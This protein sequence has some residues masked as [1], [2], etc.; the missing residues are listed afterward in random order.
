MQSI[1]KKIVTSVLIFES[2][3]I[4]KKY[5]PEIIAVTGNIGKTS[6]KDA[7]Y[8][9][10]KEFTTDIRRS[11]KSFNSEIG[12]PLTIIG[13]KN[14]W[15]NPIIWAK[16]IIQGFSLIIFKQNYPKTLILEVGA[17]KPHDIEDVS[18]WIHPDIVVMTAF[19]KTPV[20]VENFKDRDALIREKR[21]LVEALKENGT[22]IVNADDADSL[23]MKN[24]T[25]AKVMTYGISES[26]DVKA[27]NYQI[28]DNASGISFDVAYSGKNYPVKILGTIGKSNV[29]LALG[30]I[31]VA[32]TKHIDISK[33]VLE[34][35]K[36]ETPSGRMK[37]IPGMHNS[38]I[39]DDTYNA[40]PKALE[41]ALE[42]L[43]DIQVSG[44]KIAA[45]GDMAELGK[46]S[47][48]AHLEIGK[49][50][51][52]TVNVLVL[53]G[54]K[55]KKI[56]EGARQAGFNEKAIFEFN[57]AKSAGEF[58]KNTIG[59]GDAILAK[60]SQSMRM[61]KAVEQIIAGPEYK[62]LLV[63]QENEWK[64]K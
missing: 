54:T 29:Y 6:T 44:K 62:K 12:I 64:R 39:I 48:L 50:V 23:H 11:E 7:I 55:S 40:S 56:A 46:E 19:Q 4:L 31:S 33:S 32:I 63:R 24:F 52:N 61:E 9:V 53:V 14:A 59:N 57:D 58:L 21:Y 5:K 26:S 47:E 15:S 45:I 41:F 22:L 20:H 51:A 35:E 16:V 37:I 3:H 30:A 38:I 27:S 1:L 42:S 2:K 49:M 34:L 10:L 28:L 17:D 13:A 25:K 18:K 60:G 43:R 36:H 8:S